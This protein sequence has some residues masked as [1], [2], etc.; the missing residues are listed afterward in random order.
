MAKKAT[1]ALETSTAKIGSNSEVALSAAAKAMLTKIGKCGVEA[2]AGFETAG[3]KQLEAV[4]LFAEAVKDKTMTA[5]QA[6]DAAK[7]YNPE[8]AARPAG[9]RALISLTGD[10]KSFAHPAVIRAADYSLTPSAVTG[11]SHF[12]A[13]MALN[14]AIIR[15]TNGEDGK[16][17]PK[18]KLPTVNAAFAKA[19]LEYKRDTA[20]VTLTSK[21]GRTKAAANFAKRLATLAADLNTKII[22]GARESGKFNKNQIKA[23]ESLLANFA[24]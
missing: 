2:R 16:F 5:E 4:M 3:K 24:A 20:K 7:A 13:C 1:K 11:K 14:R 6:I 9:D 21:E 17:D 10:F 12:Q 19:A 15:A 8:Y 18:I 23:L 22:T